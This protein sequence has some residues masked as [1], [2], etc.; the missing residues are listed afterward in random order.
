MREKITT[1]II[2]STQSVKRN[3]ESKFLSKLN[4]M[5]ISIM[6]L[7]KG[8][9]LEKV[10]LRMLKA[11]LIKSLAGLILLEVISHKVM[12]LKDLSMMTRREFEGF[13]F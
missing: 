2:F 13:L 9:H 6:I 3:K 10:A 1:H 8:G 5:A 4:K 12:K 7:A 11:Q